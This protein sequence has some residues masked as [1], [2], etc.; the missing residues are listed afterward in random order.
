MSSSNKTEKATPRRRQKSREKGQIPRSRELPSA[1]VG[2][3]VTVILFWQLPAWFGQWRELFANSLRAGAGGAPLDRVLFQ[4]TSMLFITWMAPVLLLGWA[5]AAGSMMA[6][7]GLVFAPSTLSP[8]WDKLNP[9]RELKRLFSIEGVN[10]FLKSILPIAA[11]LGLSAMVLVR[12]WSDLIQLPRLDASATFDWLWTRAF[13]LGWK[14]GL[15]LLVMSG[16]DYLL[17]RVRHEKSL[18][19]SR[20]EVSDETKEL[21]GQ[22]LV[23]QRIRRLQRQAR[24]RQMLSD[25]ANATVVVTNPTH[26]AVALRYDADTM[27][28]PTVVAKGQNHLAHRIR[29][30]AVWNEVPVVENPPLARTLYKTASVGQS[31]PEALYATVAEI[32]AFLYR[33]QNRMGTGTLSADPGR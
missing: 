22:P 28:A 31:I 26:Y 21:Q 24:Q 16:L 11:L 32:L 25:V 15:V 13:E 10:R 14:L 6:Q 5:I 23:K 4:T 18:K 1:L 30:L 3:A 7:G 2:I 33:A 17:Q 27:E 12:D 8:N 19:M 29:K 9:T 20:Q